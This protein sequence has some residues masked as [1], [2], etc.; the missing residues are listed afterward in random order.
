MQL[1][2]RGERHQTT[3]HELPARAVGSYTK[4]QFP[5]RLHLDMKMR[6]PRDFSK[7]RR[8]YLLVFGRGHALAFKWLG[9]DGRRPGEEG[10][11]SVEA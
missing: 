10:W 4:D 5:G 11:R 1:R 7:S 6:V 9:E 8:G 2:R 3:G